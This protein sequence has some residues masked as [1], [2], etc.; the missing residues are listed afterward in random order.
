MEFYTLVL[1]KSE[2]YWVALSLENGVVGQG[3]TKEEAIAKVKE[4]INCFEEARKSDAEIY[5]SPVAIKEL[6][7]FL[8]VEGV[9]PIEEQFELRAV[10]A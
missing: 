3:K 1:R 8:S 9:E 7:E 10:H 6:H 4:A 2:G 5:T